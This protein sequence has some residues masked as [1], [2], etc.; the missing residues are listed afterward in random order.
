MILESQEEI[1]IEGDEGRLIQVMVNLLSNA[2]TYSKEETT[3][4]ISVL[5]DYR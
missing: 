5:K 4:T 3:I 2:I 1:I